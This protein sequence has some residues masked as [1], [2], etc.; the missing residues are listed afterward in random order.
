MAFGF[1]SRTIGKRDRVVYAY[2]A[3]EPAS[4]LNAHGSFLMTDRLRAN[5]GPHIADVSASHREQYASPV[6][7]HCHEERFADAGLSRIERFRGR[8]Q[9]FQ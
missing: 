2:L 1:G 3:R 4:R 6:R 7:R 5:A 8:A 9:T